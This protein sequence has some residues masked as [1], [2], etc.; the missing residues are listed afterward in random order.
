MLF[1]CQSNASPTC[2]DLTKYS[3]LQLLNLYCSLI[4]SSRNT[5]R[6]T[7]EIISHVFINFCSAFLHPGLVNAS[8][9][10]SDVHTHPTLSFSFASRDSHAGKSVI[11]LPSKVVKHGIITLKTQVESVSLSKKT[12]QR[13]ILNNSSQMLW[14]SSKQ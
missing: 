2:T 1:L 8:N 12:L 11:N 3:P 7:L 13:I 5:Y 4:T 9:I 14:T 10:L 6:N